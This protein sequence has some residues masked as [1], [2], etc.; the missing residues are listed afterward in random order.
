HN[1]VLPLFLRVIKIVR[2]E[3]CG[4]MITCFDWANPLDEILPFFS[5]LS[6]FHPRIVFRLLTSDC[7]LDGWLVHFFREEWMFERKRQDI[8]KLVYF[9]LSIIANLSDTTCLIPQLSPKYDCFMMRCYGG[10]LGKLVFYE[11]RKYFTNVMSFIASSSSHSSN[12]LHSIPMIS[13]IPSLETSLSPDSDGFMYASHICSGMKFVRSQKHFAPRTHFYINFIDNIMNGTSIESKYVKKAGPI[14]ELLDDD[15]DDETYPL[16]KHSSVI[17]YTPQHLL[18]S[19]PFY[20]WDV[21]FLMQSTYDLI[22]DTGCG[23]EI[24]FD[25]K[26]PCR[27]FEGYDQDAWRKTMEV[28][29]HGREEEGEI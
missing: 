13:M 29:V 18:V 26:V 1:E 3:Y 6:R 24:L 7:L 14:C 2:D 20:S 19:T 17:Q 25:E 23:V 15:K 16:I 27:S 4:E 8:D 10:D 22:E 9:L 21:G 28:V 12:L 11:N 5:N